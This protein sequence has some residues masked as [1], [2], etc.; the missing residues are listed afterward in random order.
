MPRLLICTECQTIEEFPLWEGPPA[1]EATDPLLND[2]VHRHQQVHGSEKPSANLLSVDEEPCTCKGCRGQQ[3]K[4]QGH[5]TEILGQLQERWTG[6]HPE[7]YATKDTFSEDALK[8]YSRHSRPKDGCI[9]WR[10][11]KKRLTPRDWKHNHVYL[12]DF[13]PCSTYYTTKLRM[14]RGAYDKEPGETE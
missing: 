7:F 6:F 13:C 12:C 11:D 14:A 5:K 10:D 1:D 2:L 9:D 4:W 3:T 8:C